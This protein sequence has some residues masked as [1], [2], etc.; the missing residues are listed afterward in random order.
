MP[1]RPGQGRQRSQDEATARRITPAIGV[2]HREIA[3][4]GEGDY[5]R[6][7]RARRRLLQP[8]LAGRAL[9]A[10]WVASTIQ[11]PS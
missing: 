6:A 2:G 4:E 5:A 10:R 1:S 11:R 8:V 7:R 3:R 9:A